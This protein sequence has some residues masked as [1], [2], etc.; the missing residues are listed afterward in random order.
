MTRA[1]QADVV[2]RIHVFQLDICLE[3]QVKAV[4][5]LEQKFGRLDVLVNNAGEAVGGMVEEVPLSG[6][7]KQ[8]E[9]N[10]S[11]PYR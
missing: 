1:E 2:E 11:G 6:W 10:F 9:T 4:R 7:R 8:L 3:E 5:E